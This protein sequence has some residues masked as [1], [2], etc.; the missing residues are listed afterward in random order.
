[1]RSHVL[2]LNVLDDADGFRKAFISIASY[3]TGDIATN[4]GA[5]C[6]AF[7]G[8]IESN[9]GATTA[10]SATEGFCLPANACYKV[11][12]DNTEMFDAFKPDQV[13]SG[14]TFTDV[15]N[16]I[17]VY[18]QGMLASNTAVDTTAAPR[19]GV[20]CA[21][22]TASAASACTKGEQPFTASETDELALADITVTGLC[23]TC[24]QGLFSVDGLVCV[25]C[26][27]GKYG[28]SLGASSEEDCEEC[29][30][31]GISAVGTANL[32]ECR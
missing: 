20:W 3:T 9:A 23:S 2:T 11:V 17:V 14:F 16:D 15:E 22:G 4:C 29:P 26:G 6:E 10:T 19:S 32:E 25:G 21:G 18:S 7:T 5:N 31:G 1:M 12:W 28:P 13:N 24:K 27:K 30:G 8:V